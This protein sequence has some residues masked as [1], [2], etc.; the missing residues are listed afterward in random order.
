MGRKEDKLWQAIATPPIELPEEPEVDVSEELAAAPPLD[1]ALQ[2]RLMAAALAQ[3]HKEASAGRMAEPRGKEGGEAPAM[4]PAQGMMRPSV[5]RSRAAGPR[6]WRRPWLMA[7][8]VAASLAMAVLAGRR[9]SLLEPGGAD[10]VPFPD[11]GLEVSGYTEQLGSSRPAYEDL[12]EAAGKEVKLSLGEGLRAYLRAVKTGAGV[13]GVNVWVEQQGRLIP[14]PVK[15]VSEP[16]AAVVGLESDASLGRLSMDGV[17]VGVGPATLLVVVGRRAGLPSGADV[18]AAVR[19]GGAAPRGWH[20]LR[21][22][23]RVVP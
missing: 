15:V 22:A 20:L 17:K 1:P 19:E 13:L 18:T 14:W 2:E 7:F 11:Y 6:W 21:Q 3:L 10:A 12:R 23:I 16:G 5:P 9:A 8:T 4:A